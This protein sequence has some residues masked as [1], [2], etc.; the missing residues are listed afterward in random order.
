MPASLPTCAVYEHKR[1]GLHFSHR[2]PSIQSIDGAALVPHT[3]AKGRRQLLAQDVETDRVRAVG[4]GRK[5]VEKNA[6]GDRCDPQADGKETA[7]DPISGVKW[8]RKT[9][10]KI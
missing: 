2:P 7:G 3:V 8:T 4:G 9:T 10:E 1:N 5:P 6:H